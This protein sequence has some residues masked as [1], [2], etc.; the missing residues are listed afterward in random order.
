MGT[1][2]VYSDGL[3]RFE[4]DSG[5]VTWF[6]QVAAPVQLGVLERAAGRVRRGR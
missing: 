5:M 2:V 1:F 4:S 6:S 3:A